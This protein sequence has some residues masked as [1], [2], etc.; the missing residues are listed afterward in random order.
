MG[1]SVTNSIA[2]WLHV[3]LALC[4][5]SVW[6]WYIIKWKQDHINAELL[7]VLLLILNPGDNENYLTKSEAC[8]SVT[9]MF[10]LLQEMSKIPSLRQKILLSLEQQVCWSVRYIYRSDRT[11]AHRNR[12]RKWGL[13]MMYSIWSFQLLSPLPQVCCYPHVTRD[14]YIWDIITYFLI[15]EALKWW[16][17]A[18]LNFMCC[19]AP[20]RLHICREVSNAGSPCI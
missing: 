11:K 17:L 13:E 16:K 8:T 12:T 9:A 7:Q 18:T 15:H 3:L 19:M 2:I 10:Q 5:T 4:P 6:K 1:W 14:G 20:A